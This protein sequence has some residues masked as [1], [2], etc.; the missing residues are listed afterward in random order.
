MPAPMDRPARTRLV[1]L[2]VVLL[3]VSVPLVIVAASS[4]GGEDEPKGS[5]RVERST[6]RPELILY[7]TGE[8]NRPERA[9]NRETVTVECV[10]GDGR[11]LATEQE[12]FPFTD[13]DQGT[14]DPHIHLT[15]DA[16][17]IGEVERCRLGG[18]EPLLEAPVL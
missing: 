6:E 2:A 13:T 5:M 8:L 18:T 7:L 10:D 15:L 4:G 9:A 1:S 3:L 11:V 17:Q 12:R 16:A 14:L